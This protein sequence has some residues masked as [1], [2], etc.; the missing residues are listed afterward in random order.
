MDPKFFRKYA[1]IVAEA[2]QFD[3]GWFGKIVDKLNWDSA[4]SEAGFKK[5]MAAYKQQWA[6]LAPKARA[7][8]PEAQR[9]IELLRKQIQQYTS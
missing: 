3:E 9:Q 4:E 8:D 1:D 2:E 7:G 6:E 5:Q